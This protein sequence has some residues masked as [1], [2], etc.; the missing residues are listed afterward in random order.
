MENKNFNILDV[1]NTKNINYIKDRYNFIDC[2]I[3]NIVFT[4]DND[5]QESRIKTLLDA[6][7]TLSKENEELKK[8]NEELKKE[9]KVL[10]EQNEVF[11]NLANLL[12]DKFKIDNIDISISFEK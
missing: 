7:D 6:I 1:L 11:S 5:T 3:N 4:I 2:Y 10:K 9:N 12:K 8:E